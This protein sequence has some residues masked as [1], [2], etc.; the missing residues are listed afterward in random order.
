[1]SRAGAPCPLPLDSTLYCYKQVRSP[2]HRKQANTSSAAL[3]YL[4]LQRTQKHAFTMMQCP[5]SR[6]DLSALPSAHQNC[7][8]DMF[9]HY[10]LS[11]ET[12]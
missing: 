1:M 10:P 11:R 6:H 8:Y 2:V 12:H 3:L 7:S 5:K 4:L 9:Q